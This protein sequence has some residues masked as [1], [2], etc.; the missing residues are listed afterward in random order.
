MKAARL[1]PLSRNPL[2]SVIVP[3]FNQGRYIRDTVDS[4]LS[5]DYR[6]IEIHVIDGSST[7]ETVDVLQSYGDIPEL[8]WV[9][10]PDNGVAEAVNKG[11]A[12][13][14]GEIVAIQSSDD[15]Y[16]P[17]AIRKMVTGLQDHG[18]PGLV[19]ADFETVDEHGRHLYQS[20][21]NPFSIRSFLSKKTWIPQPTAFFRKEMIE[22][23]GGW[24]AAY[25]N[26]D[27]EYWLRLVFR[28]RIEKIDILVAKRRLH[29]EQ[30]NV[31]K[32]EI[33]E[34]YSRMIRESE[35]LRR[36]SA[37]LRRAARAGVHMHSIKYGRSSSLL[38]KTYH[39]WAATILE[40][41]LLPVL[42]ASPLAVP[43]LLSLKAMASKLKNHLRRPAN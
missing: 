32:S 37:R 19:Y 12:R 41:S 4:I 17:G 27:T 8:N 9:S 43:G 34:S 2:V 40:P 31:R 10:E 26:A 22:A 13:A 5:Q 33:I 7:D 35:D 21:L 29:S 1:T 3:S 14:R 25:F 20:R 24:N 30:R 23:C 42:K 6:P 15:M 11:F 16:L 36:S 39:L 28:T 18:V 38:V